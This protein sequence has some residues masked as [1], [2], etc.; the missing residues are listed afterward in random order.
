MR[1]FESERDGDAEKN[2]VKFYPVFQ[3]DLRSSELSSSEKSRQEQE[4]LTRNVVFYT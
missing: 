1:W 3:L 4:L 2:T